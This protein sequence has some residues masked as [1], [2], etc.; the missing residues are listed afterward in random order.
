MKRL[1]FIRDHIDARD[2]FFKAR[3]HACL[4]ENVDLSDRD[5]P[6]EN[7][8]NTGSC[9]GNAVAGAIEFLD[10]ANRSYTDKSR[11]FIYYN[12]RDYG[13]YADEDCGC[14]IRNA[15]KAVVNYGVCPESV[16]PFAEDRVTSRP[17]L[18]AYDAAVEVKAIRY[19]RIRKTRD[20]KAALASG[21]PVI[22][23]LT[24]YSSF[25][26]VGPDGMV[27]VPKYFLEHTLGGHAMLAV[28]YKQ[29]TGSCYFI[30]RNSWGEEW[31]DKGYCYIHEK[32]ME[33]CFSDAW[34]IRGISGD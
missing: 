9:V 28:G 26:D 7:Q 14:E 3:K 33:R 24:L 19:E 5:T 11:L 27:P 20:I 6:I 15:I 23:G 21:L 10:F 18:A 34:V 13:G 16:W 17:S 2:L 29:I 31:G 25:S 22:F 30:V 12:A 32:N 8:G 4:P 1:G